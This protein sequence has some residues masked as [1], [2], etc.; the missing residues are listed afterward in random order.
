VRRL[1]ARPG[2]EAVVAGHRDRLGQMNTELAGA[3]LSAHGRRLVVITA[4]EV[5]DDLVRYVAQVLR[6]FC[7]RWYGRR[8]TRNRAER[9]SQC[10]AW[11][12]GLT[13]SQVVR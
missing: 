1:L 7:A 3:A 13:R 8:S 12:V 10:A 4:G 2:V 11:D 6:L 9:T 5:G